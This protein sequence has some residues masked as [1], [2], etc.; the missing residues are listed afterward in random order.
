MNTKDA[1]CDVRFRAKRIDNGETIEGHYVTRI[2]SGVTLHNI[3]KPELHDLIPIDKSTL[4]MI[5]VS[6]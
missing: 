1:V 4:E 3:T 5:S 2:I 6:I